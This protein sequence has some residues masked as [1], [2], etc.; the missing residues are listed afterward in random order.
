MVAL[1]NTQLL[2]FVLVLGVRATACEEHLA[3]CATPAAPT[4]DAMED[5]GEGEGEGEGVQAGMFDSDVLEMGDPRPARVAPL[6]DAARALEE[7][8]KGSLAVEL[9]LAAGEAPAN[10]WATALRA[11][12]AICQL[13]LEEGLRRLAHSC[14]LKTTRRSPRPSSGRRRR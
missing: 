14:R 12:A 6:T 1:K 4:G 5:E 8:G 10:S 13:A 9:R 7:H 2:L 11:P 3:R